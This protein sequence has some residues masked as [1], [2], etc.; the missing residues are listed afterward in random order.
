MEAIMATTSFDREYVVTE[1]KS[2]NKLSSDMEK[3]VKVQAAKR[4]YAKER[5]KGVRILKQQFSSLETC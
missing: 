1:I 4:D 3:P 5:Q 2:A